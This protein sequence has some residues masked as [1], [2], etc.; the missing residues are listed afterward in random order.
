MSTD[1]PRPI[2]TAQIERLIADAEKQV[3]AALS[4]CSGRE[5]IAIVVDDPRAWKPSSD[6]IEEMQRVDQV[7]RAGGRPL[8]S[9]YPTSEAARMLR[10]SAASVADLVVP[11]GHIPVVYIH[12]DYFTVIPVKLA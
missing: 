6:P 9:A 10:P 12:G 5:E 2:K 3:A 1:K 7:D 8:V 11:P 4:V